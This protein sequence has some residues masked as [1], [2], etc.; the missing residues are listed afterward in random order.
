MIYPLNLGM[1]LSLAW[2]RYLERYL[3]RKMWIYRICWPCELGYVRVST[4][5]SR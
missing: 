5:K 3:G 1:A 4:A 2:H